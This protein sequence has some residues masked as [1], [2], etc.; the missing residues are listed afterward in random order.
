MKNKTIKLALAINLGLIGAIAYQ[1]FSI[2]KQEDKVNKLQKQIQDK[3]RQ[4]DS[5]DSVNQSLHQLSWENI[6]YW[7]DTLGIHHKDVV[8]QQIKLETGNLT[9]AIC[10]ENNNLFGMKEARVRE[11]TAQGTKRNHAYYDSYIDSIKDYKLWQDMHEVDGTCD[12]YAFLHKAGYA[13]ARNYINTLK[14][15]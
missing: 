5:L 7:L 14:K 9:S 13:E 3:Q 8:I 12:Y 2:S 10:L 15:M 6:N 4:I 11:T 1:S